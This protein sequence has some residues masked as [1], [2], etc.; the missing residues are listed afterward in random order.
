MSI[1]TNLSVTGRW[2][3]YNAQINNNSRPLY[4][5]APL[6]NYFFKVPLVG[7]FV[8]L[9]GGIDRPVESPLKAYRSMSPKRVKMT[10]LLDHILPK[11]VKGVNGS[12]PLRG[13]L[14]RHPW[15]S[16]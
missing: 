16:R 1:S 3:K 4:K 7:R 10:L 12:D 11:G 5:S 6:T 9:V 13:T 15:E 14:S 2:P 8:P